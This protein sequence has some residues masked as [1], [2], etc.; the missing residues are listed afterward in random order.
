MTANVS[1]APWVAIW[2]AVLLPAS[3]FG[4]AP[5]KI[6]F[7]RDIRP[8]LSDNCYA[9]H[10]PD[11]HK[12]KG[13][14][15]LDRK[16]DAFKT[17]K[18]G[19]RA[20]IPGNLATSTLVTR[21]QTTDADDV[22]PPPEFGR[23]LTPEQVS[24]LKQWVQE[25][26]E[27][28]NHWSFI[29]P[30]RAAVPEVKES[31]WVRNTV[32]RF[33]L[34]ELEKR[35]LKP[36]PE[37]EKTTL[38]RRATMDLTGLPPTIE[39][40]DAYLADASGDAY[41]KV[42]DRLL[43][44]SHYGERMAQNWLDLAR[45]ADSNG[46]HFDGV[47]FMWLWRDGVI[48][49]FNQN[50]RFDQFT[51]EQLAGDMI[52]NATPAQRVASGFMRNGMTN[53][54]GGADPDEYLNK[55]IVDRVNTFGAT[56]L[57]ITVGCTE[58]HDHKYDPMSTR[59]FYRMYAFFHNVP[60][61]GLDRTRVDN[62]PP[63]LPMPSPEQ[64][65]KL[66]EYEFAL[67]DAEKNL[68]DR[69][70]ELGETQEK[71]ERETNA[72]PPAPLDESAL[73]GLITFDGSLEFQRGNAGASVSVTN[74]MG[75]GTNA[76]VFVAGRRGQ[77]LKLDGKSAVEFGELIAVERTNAFSLSAWVRV[78]GD[79]A[80]AS[81]MEKGPG[82]R[83]WD[84]LVSDRR[85]QVHLIHQ[86]PDDA[87]KVKT[88]EQFPLNQ[89]FHAMV[90]YDGSG[91]AGGV[92]VYVN[93]RARDLETEKD[94]LKGTVLMAE[95]VRVG[96]RHGETFLTGL[97]DDLRFYSKALGADDARLST[98][99]G[100]LPI[101]A[102]SR[103][104]RSDEERGELQRYYKEVHAVDFLRS[105]EALGL[106]RKAKEELVAQ[107]PTTMVMAEMSKPRDTHILVR[108]DFRTKGE[109]VLPGTPAFLPPLSEGAPNRLTLA[110]WVVS[111]SHP[112][113][114][115]VTAN[116]WW[117][118]LFGTGIVKTLNDFGSQ[119]EWPSHPELLDWLAVQLREGGPVGGVGSAAPGPWDVKG[120]VR[121]LVTSSS[122]RQAASVTPEKLE[123][124]LYNRLLTRG[125]RLRLDAEFL[126]DNALAVSGL[127]NRKI[128]GPSIRPYQPAGIWDGTDARYEQDHGDA[129]YRRGMYVFWK[130]SAHYPSFAT[131]DAPNREVCTFL[132]QRTQTPLQ[133]M[134]LMNDPVYVEAAR[135]LAQRVLAEEPTDL[136][137]RLVR[138][139]RHTLGRQPQPDEMAV[140]QRA[141]DQQRAQFQADPKSAEALTKVGESKV[142]EKA[143]LVEVASLTAVANVLLNLSEAIT[144]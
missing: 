132:R 5:G 49:S 113:T 33:V 64:A 134:V 23:K 48:Q 122:Y 83:G 55:Y 130:R 123:K 98:F 116:R 7:N 29:V 133:S 56:W 19:D 125:P 32:D 45:Y 52:P 78:E 109:K 68:T 21:I 22:M 59:E 112:L 103:G 80:I 129:L 16:E 66:A 50:Q 110:K 25:G 81:K 97:V 121:M 117:A 54:E 79:G 102:K 3:G 20:I 119:G 105:E 12:R 34:S 131:F 118:M 2:V 38:I 141:Y 40:V 37:A 136:R 69:S 15:R 107:I 138:T 26:A 143:D 42:V 65:T 61:K 53:D 6:D 144:K 36:E 18:S 90:T 99:H 28:Q 120:F 72:N 89:W 31:S 115:R 57:G 9:C 95:P 82:Y 84:L 24:L 85:L 62:P 88:R 94:Q 137:R 27:W 67:R 106:A 114:A 70:N 43:T 1:I 100:F 13:G 73:I 51:V 128:G 10:G 58:C 75:I 46:Y 77:G 91:K 41:E 111:P 60:E 44:S 93:G 35:G 63:R 11:E 4:A 101:V 86:W 139:F 92:R 76:P 126:R 127:L 142:P 8:I 124:D 140:L 30:E 74:G 39:E 96:S 135:G 14:L 47:R 108:G 17:L 104:T 71:W 87:L